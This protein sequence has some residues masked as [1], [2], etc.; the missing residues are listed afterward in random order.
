MVRSV[1]AV[2][3]QAHLSPEH[4]LPDAPLGFVVG[5]HGA[6]LVD[7][8]P[9]AVP[10]TQDVLGGTTGLFR[11][12]GTIPQGFQS[13][14]DI[15]LDRLHLPHQGLSVDLVALELVPQ[16]EGLVT[17]ELQHAALGS[18]LARALQ[19]AL[20]V[21]PD[22]AVAELVDRSSQL[23][24]GLPPVAVDDAA[25]A[26]AE[27]VFGLLPTAPRQEAEGLGIRTRRDPQPHP[28]LPASSK[29]GLIRMH[30]GRPLHFGVD[31]L[32]RLR[33]CLAH[34]LAAGLHRSQRDPHAEHRLASPS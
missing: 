14:P 15:G 8:S 5:G 26:L 29:A 19:H 18:R 2:H 13:P 23:L 9:Q 20:E 3:A 28:I 4:S 6:I 32:G 22:V 31:G 11:R 30:E 25:E 12:V 34:R 17:G 33:C 24:I 10:L 7:I 1:L 27:K 16:V 21:A